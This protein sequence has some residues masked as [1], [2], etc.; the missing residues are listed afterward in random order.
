MSSCEIIPLSLSP[1]PLPDLDGV[2]VC[3]RLRE[4]SNLPI[5]VLVSTVFLFVT[6]TQQHELDALKAAGISLYRASLPILLLAFCISL[7]SGLVQETVLPGHVVRRRC[8]TGVRWPAQHP[9]PLAVADF[10][11]EVGPATREQPRG[12]LTG[13]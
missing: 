9:E 13:R 4:W 11:G 7:A 3:R 8:R 5:I 10:V 2:E 6:L 12:Q 1:I